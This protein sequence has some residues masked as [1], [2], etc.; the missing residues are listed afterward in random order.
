MQGMPVIATDIDGSGTLDFV[1]ENETNQ[2]FAAPRLRQ[3]QFQTSMLDIPQP[4]HL[5]AADVDGDGFDDVLIAQKKMGANDEETGSTGL[6][7]V[8]GGPSVLLTAPVFFATS[9]PILTMATG[10]LS[11][12]D[13]ASDTVFVLDSDA[14]LSTGARAPCWAGTVTLR[15]PYVFDASY[16]MLPNA[17]DTSRTVARTQHHG[18]PDRSGQPFIRRAAF[19]RT[20]SVSHRFTRPPVVGHAYGDLDDTS[21]STNFPMLW[22]V[23][24]S[25]GARIDSAS[26]AVWRRPR[27]PSR[28][29]QWPCSLT[30]KVTTSCCFLALRPRS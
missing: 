16:P 2:D 28:T 22:M 4:S 8:Y 18:A 12:G 23:P 10:L 20:D 5:H 17:D 30:E 1:V 6:T 11:G 14:M 9:T 3:R 13:A 7:V 25:E 29:G 26:I 24:L 15:L 21:S 27:L 19:M